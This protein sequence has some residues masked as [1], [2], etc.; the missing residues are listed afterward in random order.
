MN[1]QNKIINGKE[2]YERLTQNNQATHIEYG[3]YYLGTGMHL[4]SGTIHL[5]KDEFEAYQE[6][7]G[8]LQSVTDENNRLLYP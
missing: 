8:R 4:V 3:K 7:Y 6:K 2:I 5:S 1:S